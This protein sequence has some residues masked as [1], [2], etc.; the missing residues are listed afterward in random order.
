MSYRIST[1]KK[2]GLPM[3]KTTL[4][5]CISILSLLLQFSRAQRASADDQA[6][7]SGPAVGLHPIEE[8]GLWG[9]VDND[10]RVVIEPRFQYAEDFHEGRAAVRT[11]LESGYI[12]A[13]GS[14]AVVLPESSFPIGRFSE[15]LARFLKDGHYGCVDLEGKI[16]IP[17]TYDSFNDFSE[18]L[19]VVSTDGVPRDQRLSRGPAKEDMERF[20]YVDRNGQVVLPLRYAAA[21]SFHDGL[22]LI[23]SSREGIGLI[24][25]Q[26]IDRTGKT[27]ILPDS[28]PTAPG[29][30]VGSVTDFS[31]AHA[32]LELRSRSR[33]PGIMIV[34][35]TKGKEVARVSGNTSWP[36]F[37]GIVQIN[38]NNKKGYFDTLG[39][40]VLPPKFDKGT[41]FHEGLALVRLGKEL[42]YINR[43]GTVVARG[44]TEGAEA[45]N[46]ADDFH[47]GLARVH[48]GGRFT[49][50]MDGPN[51]WIG[52]KWCYIDRTGKIIRVC[53]FDG[54]RAREDE[55]HYSY[56][57]RLLR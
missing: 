43:E 52:G 18:G 5:V 16:V 21:H 1:L 56:G 6:P 8:A 10:G 40:V 25:R 29:H 50:I 24:G 44:G 28:F 11:K 30:F 54:S 14:M 49:E 53:K 33:V 15:G 12:R 37:E 20:G 32:L 26:F 34:I 48:I 27:V 35:D 46:D 2:L 19:A 47:D 57:K 3:P 55:P 51:S 36:F 42:Q 17:P 38:I 22:A 45:W 39:K 13:D 9:F 23:Y 41:D 31:N 4:S 7:K